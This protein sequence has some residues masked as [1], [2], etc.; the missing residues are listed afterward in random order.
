M[1]FKV[2]TNKITWQGHM[3]TILQ[4]LSFLGTSSIERMFHQCLLVFDLLNSWKNLLPISKKVR[5][6]NQIPEYHVPSPGRLMKIIHEQSINEKPPNQVKYLG[7]KP[8]NLK[9][10]WWKTSQPW[11]KMGEENRKIYEVWL[12]KKPPNLV[13]Y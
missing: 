9:Y 12:V 3:A 8:K 1:L 5:R 4:L 7:R 11:R 10:V 6:K 2:M 13:G